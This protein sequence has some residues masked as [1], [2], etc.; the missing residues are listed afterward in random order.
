MNGAGFGKVF[1]Q[2]GDDAIREGC[3]AVVA[4]FS[5]VD[6]DAVVFKVYIFDAQTKTFHEAQPGA[7]HDLYHEFVGGSHVLDDGFG[8][9]FRENGGD[10]FASF[11]A[12]EAE[13][14]L[15]EFEVED[16][17]VEEENGTNDLILGG[18]GGFAVYDEVGDKLFNFVRSHFFG[19]AFVVVENVLPHPLDVGLFGAWGVLFEADG[20]FVLFEEFFGFLR[21]LHFLPLSFGACIMVVMQSIRYYTAKLL[22]CTPNG[23]FIQRAV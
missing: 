18:G 5:V 8:F 11:G 3:L 22:L 17:A 7:V 21:S 12:D 2:G 13:I 9:V 19:M 15:V 23:V 10:A 6:E 16:V 20:F 14:G 1:A 4:A